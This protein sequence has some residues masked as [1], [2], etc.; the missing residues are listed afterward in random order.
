MDTPNP[1][2]RAF[3][4]EALIAAGEAVHINQGPAQDI[5]FE[6]LARMNMADL[7]AR[8]IAGTTAIGHTDRIHLDEIRDLLEARAMAGT[9]AIIG[10]RE[11]TNIR[12]DEIRDLVAEMPAI[13]PVPEDNIWAR[14]NINRTHRPNLNPEQAQ[15]IDEIIAEYNLR[16]QKYNSIFLKDIENSSSFSPKLKITNNKLCRGDKIYTTEEIVEALN[17]LL[18]KEQDAAMD[19]DPSERPWIKINA[20]PSNICPTHLMVY[21]RDINIE[22]R[23]ISGAQGYAPRSYI[24]WNWT[25]ED[26]DIEWYRIHASENMELPLATEGALPEDDGWIPY[27]HATLRV[28]NEL[29]RDAYPA[30]LRR[31]TDGTLIDVILVNGQREIA[32]RGILDWSLNLGNYAIQYFRVHAD[33]IAEPGPEPTEPAP[34]DVTGSWIPH[35]ATDNRSPPLELSANFPGGRRIQIEMRDGTFNESDYRNFNWSTAA[36]GGTIIQYRLLGNNP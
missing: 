34:A 3:T 9:T 24:R 20:S 21:D 4:A 29:A 28:P 31:Y 19:N 5:R 23:L 27:N 13:A 15:I 14:Q 33:H 32:E 2:G 22:Y 16:F 10:N 7:E 26:N 30:E 17:E 36:E 12:L 6:E 1:P 18:E 25:G 8:A 35:T 11:A